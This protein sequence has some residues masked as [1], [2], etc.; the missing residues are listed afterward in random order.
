MRTKEEMD[1][2]DNCKIY[3]RLRKKY[4]S[5]SK[6]EI[7]CDFCPANRGCN[8]KWKKRYTKSWKKNR[9]TQWKGVAI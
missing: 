2:T 8:S 1:F 9:K 3:K 5:I 7:R 4:L 6:G